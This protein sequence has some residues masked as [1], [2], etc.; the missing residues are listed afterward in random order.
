MGSGIGDVSP[1]SG[2]IGTTTNVTVRGMGLQTVTS[3]A[4]VPPDGVTVGN[5]SINS[6]G[7]EL[8]LNMQIDPAAT[9]GFRRLVVSSSNGPLNFLQPTASQFLISAPIPELDTVTPP[10]LLAGQPSVSITLRGRNLLN[11]TGV[12]LDPPADISVIPPYVN[13]AD[14]TVLNFAVTVG[15]GAASGIRPV[16]VSTAAGDSSTVQQPGNSLHIASQLGATYANI[17]SPIVGVALGSTNPPPISVDRTVVSNV[18]GVSVETPPVSNTD[19]RTVV[20]AKVGVALGAIAQSLSPDGFLQGAAG[21]ISVTG[22][23]LDTIT[24]VSVTPAT[25]LGLG[26]PVS[27]EGGTRLTIPLT[28][29]A[30]A[31]LVPRR[32]RLYATGN[33]ELAFSDPNTA[34]FGIGSLP[35]AMSSVSPIILQQGKTAT[36]TVRGS[37]LKSVNALIFEPPTGL[38]AYAGVVWSQDGFGE[39][40]T[41]PVTVDATAPLGDRVIR[42]HVPGGSTSATANPANT[43]TVVVPQ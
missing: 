24:A 14:G 12:R 35:T 18:I 38:N 26:A 43:V 7:T 37:N 42:L 28:V 11:V 22:L 36:L 13:N 25:G 41:V 31:H 32:L 17:T 8:T 4:L 39:L 6:D 16:I 20:S 5:P 10:V 21:E 19:N 30:D 40:L 34:L 33:T 9:L 2:V 15:A 23:G 3:V 1:R 27:S 29:A